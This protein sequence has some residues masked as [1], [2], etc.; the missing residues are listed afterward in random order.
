VA[1]ARRYRHLARDNARLAREAREAD[2]AKSD[3]L[4]V[5]SHDLR[6]PLNAIMGHAELLAMGI[7]EPLSAAGVERVE[8]I[9]LGARHL[10]YLI[11]ELLSF[12]RLDAGRDELHLQ[13]VDACTLVREVAAVVE[14][15]AAD[16]SLAF[17][18]DVPA[19]PL[20][21]RTDPDRL[22]QVLLNLVGNAVKYTREGEVRLELCAE[23]GRAVFHV[24][25]T[26]IGI[27]PE[28][29]EKIFEP[30]WQVDP[31][32]R[33]AD[34]GTGLGL[35]VVRRMVR[36]LGG[37]IAVESEPGRG[38]TFTVRLPPRPAE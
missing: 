19:A 21:L 35:S 36:L 13:E 5:I 4:A 29:L 28:H 33:A 25:D 24:R 6:T 38:S 34:G 30:F 32:Q 27:A 20:P 23:G 2:Q 16:R 11:D 7:P 17:C 26:G 1:A 9:R 10:L 22:R 31:G 14:P 3:L 12:A 15:L 18:R 8:R 37:E